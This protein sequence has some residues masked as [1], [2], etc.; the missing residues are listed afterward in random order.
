MT[1]EEFKK[2]LKEQ[3]RKL[4]IKNED[5]GK[6]DK[7]VKEICNKY[8]LNLDEVTKRKINIELKKLIKEQGNE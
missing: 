7:A 3:A 1:R 8:A 5:A 6:F 2:N 4:I